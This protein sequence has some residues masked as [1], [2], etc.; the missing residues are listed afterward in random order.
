MPAVLAHGCTRLHTDVPPTPTTQGYGYGGGAAP[1]DA[2]FST[3]ALQ[4]EQY[5]ASGFPTHGPN[6][7]IMYRAKETGEAYYHNHRT[8]TTQWERWVTVAVGG[9]RTVGAC[10]ARAEAGGVPAIVC[11]RVCCTSRCAREH[12]AHS[13]ITS[14]AAD[15]A[16]GPPSCAT[17]HPTRRLNAQADGLAQ[18]AVSVCWPPLN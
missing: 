17:L 1:Y 12:G 2:P 6:G 11:V 3:D 16:K 5:A 10:T 18:H 13:R 9:P 7:W 4:Q 8:G 14:Q 15:V